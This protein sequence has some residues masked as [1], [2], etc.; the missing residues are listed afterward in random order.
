MTTTPPPTNPPKPQRRDRRGR[1]T[2]QDGQTNNSSSELGDLTA[3]IYGL[4][5]TI[6]PDKLDAKIN[7]QLKGFL[8]DQAAKQ[9]RHHLIKFAISCGLCVVISNSSGAIVDGAFVMHYNLAQARTFWQSCKATPWDCVMG[10]VQPKFNLWAKP[11]DNVAAMLDLIAWGEGTDDR[12]DISYTGQSFASF[13]DHPR[14]L[15]TAN[16]VSSDAAG[17]YQFLSPTWDRIKAKLNLPDFAPA[18]QDKAAIQLMKDTGCYGAAVRG[19]VATFADRCWTVWASFQSGQGAKLDARQRSHSIAA[20]QTKYQEFLGGRAGTTLIK[21]LPQLSVTSPMAT[22]RINP[23]SG[24]RQPHNGTDYACALGEMVVSPIAGTFRRG[25]P[26]PTGFGNSWVT[27]E[28][29]N[30]SITI[31]HT[32]AL[33]VQDGQTVTAGQPIAECGNEGTSSAPHVHL[34]IRRHGQ[35]IDP[36]TLFGAL[37]RQR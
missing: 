37:P 33:L 28:G 4:L 24:K 23:V 13:T 31:G 10:K 22:S 34:E 1:Y 14:K 32:R 17:R 12:Y 26:D 8:N 2:R 3:A 19:D 5:A 7:R 15:F 18:S 16:G 36:E 30:Q 20:L 35:L 11:V 29:T 6:A 25:N 27:V 9:E 21:P